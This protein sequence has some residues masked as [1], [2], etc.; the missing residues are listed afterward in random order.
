MDNLERF[1]LFWLIKYQVSSLVASTLHTLPL[2]VMLIGNRSQ[3][4]G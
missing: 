4:N 1:P 2:K 3:E